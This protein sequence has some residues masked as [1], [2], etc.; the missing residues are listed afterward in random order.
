M[1]ITTLV[2]HISIRFV[3]QFSCFLLVYT[4]FSETIPFDKCVR[5]GIGAIFCWLMLANTLKW[6]KRRNIHYCVFSKLI[7]FA[8][9]S[10]KR[11]KT[12][13][14]RGN[15]M[16]I[17]T[18]ALHRCSST[19]PPILLRVPNGDAKTTLSVHYCHVLNLCGALN[20]SLKRDSEITMATLLFI[21]I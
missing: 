18:N 14:D 12:I 7:P 8:N 2:N 5:P 11:R 15:D 9:S 17:N 3:F 16:V 1:E 13:V 19:S 6:N 20:E 10:R 4:D 21:C